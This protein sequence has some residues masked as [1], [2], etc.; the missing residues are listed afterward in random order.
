MNRRYATYPGR[1]N[2][3]S[4]WDEGEARKKRRRIAGT[5]GPNT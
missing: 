5:L 4:K 2:L 3:F 1:Y